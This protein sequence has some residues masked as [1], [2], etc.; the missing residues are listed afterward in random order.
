[1]TEGITRVHADAAGGEVR[2]VRRATLRVLEGPDRGAALELGDRSVTLIGTHPDADLVLSDDTVSRR[3]AEL[4]LE[5]AG[6]VLRDLGSTNGITL[7]GVRMREAVIDPAC[8]PPFYVGSSRLQLEFAAEEVTHALSP[9]ERFGEALGRSS[10]MRRLFA[11]LERVAPTDASVM[12]LGES[13][14]GKEVLAE[15]IHRGSARADGP[16]VVFDCAA[17]SPALIESE[18]FGHEAGAFT[19][20]N[21]ARPGIFEEASGGTLF[22]DEIGELPLPL[23]PKLL[24]ILAEGEVRRVGSSRPKQL[25]VRVVCATHRDLG[26]AKQ[27]GSFRADLYFRLAVVV[28][29]IPA[30]RVRPEDIGLL[31]QHF[32][33]QLRPEEDPQRLLTPSL[34]GTLTSYAW[35][36]NVRELRNVIERLVSAGDLASTVR[37]GAATAAEDYAAARRE[38][39]DRFERGF[40]QACLDACEGNVTRAAERAGISR[41]MFHRLMS[42]HAITLS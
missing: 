30:L 37:A 13:G 3:H 38:A 7:S 34:R 10:E 41:Q 4:T 28:A 8:P 26:R 6:Y 24:R 35:P 18:L 40:V 5:D 15:A 14:T 25:D 20:A 39:I 1:M 23:Q 32:I 22:I 9:S 33:R 2:V 21:R 29:R 19:G 27:E 42:R 12:L 17:V 16:F 11:L 36:G 31:A